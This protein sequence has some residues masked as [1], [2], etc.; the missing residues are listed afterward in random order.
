M[1]KKG[2]SLL[3]AACLLL[4]GCGKNADTGGETIGRQAEIT[5]AIWAD[6]MDEV[7]ELT[8]GFSRKYPGLS[9][10]MVVFSSDTYMEDVYRYLEEGGTLDVIPC[11]NN[12]EF[13]ACITEAGLLDLTDL[14]RRD[15]VDVSAYGP[16]YDDMKYQGFTY[17]LPYKKTANVLYYNCDL[18]D[19][20]GVGYPGNNMTW[21]EFRWLAYRMTDAKKRQYGAYFHTWPQCWYGLGLQE[22]AT[23][24]DV[25]LSPFAE[26]LRYRQQLEADGSIRTYRESIELGSNYRTDFVNGSAAMCV[27]GDYMISQLRDMEKVGQLSFRWDVAA[28][29]HPEGSEANV[30]WGTANTVGIW[31]GCRESETAWKFVKYMAGKEGAAV[32]ASGGSLPAY[33]DSDIEQIYLGDG[34]VNPKN[35]GI[36]LEAKVFFENPTIEGADEIKN[37]IYKEEG[38]KTLIEGRS[39]EETFEVI[40][41]RI[42]RVVEGSE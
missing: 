28:I 41:M 32:Y 13:T 4:A 42:R 9:A 34:R 22:G 7:S 1:D 15:E 30:T 23:I 38:A 6:E 8:A 11:K 10:R 14:I 20:A 33:F 25:D 27:I 39:V 37:R 31:S 12:A 24:I 18:F 3:L 16:L 36:L 40:A 21:E 17:G 19:E 35:I 5:V 2:W 26:G 29:P